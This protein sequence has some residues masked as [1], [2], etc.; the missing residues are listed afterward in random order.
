MA[1]DHDDPLNLQRAEELLH[2]LKGQIRSNPESANLT[3]DAEALAPWMRLSN[4]AG[5]HVYATD[6]GWRSEI[7]FRNLPYG[8]GSP[9]GRFAPYTTEEEALSA[10]IEDLSRCAE[11]EN[12]PLPNPRERVFRFPFDHAMIPV[13][14]EMIEDHVEWAGE[15]DVM[16]DAVSEW[17]SHL[18]NRAAGDGILTEDLYRSLEIEEKMELVRACA[19]AVAVGLNFFGEPPGG[20]MSSPDGKL[21]FAFDEVAIP[22]LAG[23][24][25]S[26]RRTARD[27][28][29]TADGV[30]EWLGGLRQSAA[31]DDDLTCEVFDALTPELKVE[32]KVACGVAM[33]LGIFRSVRAEGAAPAVTIRN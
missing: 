32:I 24:I 33:A 8:L 27:E 29:M 13:T 20:T 4:A 15:L 16:S 1:Y 6:D 7:A 22:V 31:G 12:L 19:G 10:V 23:G 2:V 5:I 9:C 30:L 11:R 18:R 25:P 3:A 14:G 28:G 26:Y 17:M 21:Y